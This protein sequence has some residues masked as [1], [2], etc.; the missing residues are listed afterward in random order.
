M[1][2]EKL[3]LELGGA[4]GQPVALLERDVA[5]PV[6]DL[7]V[8]LQAGA[9]HDGLGELIADADGLDST[10]GELAV[11]PVGEGG[12]LALGVLL[13]VGVLRG[14]QGRRHRGRR[15]W[16]SLSFVFC[17]RVVYALGE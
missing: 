2:R 9:V 10:G 5:A 6:R 1:T 14:G 11:G 12:A 15:L 16:G 8:A 3:V 4:V 17:F 7:D 13:A